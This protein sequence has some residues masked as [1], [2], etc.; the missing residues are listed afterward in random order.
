MDRRPVLPLWT[1]VALGLTVVVSGLIGL[2]VD[3]QGFALEVLSSLLAFSVALLVGLPLVSSAQAAATDRSRRVAVDTVREALHIA[4]RLASTIETQGDPRSILGVRVVDHDKGLLD[5]LIYVLGRLDEARLLLL[6][7]DVN[8]ARR[9][10]RRRH[11]VAHFAKWGSYPILI[12]N[13]PPRPNDLIPMAD[14]VETLETYSNS[15]P[16]W[17]EAELQRGSR[18]PWWERGLSKL[19]SKN[20]TPPAEPTSRTEEDW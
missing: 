11:E 20:A 8:L 13:S 10:A 5:R 4:S 18:H 14:L 19:T 15:V 17:L 6:V 1:R 2:R 9:F 16:W 7:D 3:R 12:R